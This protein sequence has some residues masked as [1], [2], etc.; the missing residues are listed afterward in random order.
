MYDLLSRAGETPLRDEVYYPIIGRARSNAAA[1]IA[2]FSVPSGGIPPRVGSTLG[3][4]LC[5]R[6]DVSGGT[7]TSAGTSAPVYND[8]TVSIGG[9]RDVIAAK[10][11]GIWV[12]I[13]EDCGAS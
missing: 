2:V 1:E 9:D 8:F 4:A 6:M 12:V 13:A 7:R 11:D 10:I 5:G 3:S